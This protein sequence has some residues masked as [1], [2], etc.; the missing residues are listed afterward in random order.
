MQNPRLL[1]Y[2]QLLP[3]R[4]L[5]A[6]VTADA[7]SVNLAGRASPTRKPASPWLI[8]AGGNEPATWRDRRKRAAADFPESANGG[9]CRRQRREGD[10]VTAGRLITIDRAAAAPDA[11]PAASA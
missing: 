1:N 3:Q 11:A 10:P 6:I 7:I 4:L 9:K 8:V 5:R 2:A